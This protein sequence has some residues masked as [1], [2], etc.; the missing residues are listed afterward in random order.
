MRTQV[1]RIVTLGSDTGR[2]GFFPNGVNGRIVTPAGYA[3]AVNGY[4]GWPGN[5]VRVCWRV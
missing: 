2:G 4:G 3:D 5:L 1:L